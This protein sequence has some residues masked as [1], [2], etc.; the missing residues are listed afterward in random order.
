MK[1]ASILF[2]APLAT[3]HTIFVQLAA[4]GKT[5]DVQYAIRDPSYDGP[6]TDVTSNNIACNGP[7]NPTQPSAK[8]I[9]VTAGSNVT[10]V[11]RHT[12]T[13]GA[14]DVM[15]AGHK[16]PVMAYMKKVTDATK[17][18]GVGAGW[19]KIMEHG[20][21]SQSGVWATDTVI[22][23]AGK[24]VITIPDCIEDGQYLLRAEMIALH[25][26]RSVNGAQLYMEC[27]QINVTGGKGAQKP[28]TYSI[29]GIYKSSDPG[30]LINI[31]PM[32]GEYTIPAELRE[33]PHHTSMTGI[34]LHDRYGQVHDVLEQH[35]LPTDDF[36]NQRRTRRDEPQQ[37]DDAPEGNENQGAEEA[38]EAE[39]AEGDSVF[40]PTYNFAPG[41]RG[42]VLRPVF[43]D[44]DQDKDIKVDQSQDQ[45][46]HGLQLQVMKWGLIPSWT[47]TRPDYATM[48]KTIN[49]R[50]DSLAAGTGLWAPLRG[51]KRCVVVAEGFYEW[52]KAGPKERVPHY[53]RR[54][55]GLPL[56]LAGLWDVRKDKDESKEYT[57][58]II[59]T[60]SNAGL[61]FLHDRMP[62]VFEYRSPE[63]QAWLD[64][65]RTAWSP[66]LQALLKPWPHTADD[67][68][69]GA[70][71]LVDVVSKDVNKAG[72]SSASMVVPVASASNKSNIANFFKG[73]AGKTKAVKREAQEA[74][75]EDEPAKRARLFLSSP[76]KQAPTAR[77]ESHT[78]TTPVKT[79]PVKASHAATVSARKVPNKGAAARTP[80]KKDDKAGN[81][82]K[83]TSFFGRNG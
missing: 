19:F 43:A 32:K 6:Q 60:D 7:P 65:K 37:E 69:D 42:I 77:G 68:D 63:L 34:Q 58:T 16:G 26:A 74:G 78:P 66:E 47:K 83:I 81:S 8:I 40:W 61:R 29:P 64:P 1:L 5:Y 3:A 48:L 52:R 13:S 4:G 45:P 18:N 30:L 50:A 82:Q 20:Y 46:Q 62:V 36:H 55:D 31:Y 2:V 80:S 57:Y 44:K 12:L 49:C 35:G 54:R 38:Q 59:T 76:I 75:T 53:I 15:D 22:N 39:A 21:N 41:Y 67:K 72:H 28:T 24:Q 25:G 70:A 71:L 27:A 73:E 10:A 56:L 11:W 51:R 9:D 14:N 17:D 33:A 23:N 79:T